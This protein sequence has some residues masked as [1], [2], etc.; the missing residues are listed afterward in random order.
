MRQRLA[1][2]RALICRLRILPLDVPDRASNTGTCDIRQDCKPATRVPVYGIVRWDV[3]APGALRRS[4]FQDLELGNPH[5]GGR[6]AAG[7]IELLDIPGSA[8]T[9]EG[10]R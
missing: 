4:T 8:R 10:T 9:S 7:F 3:Q 6:S 1:L 5:C 2:A